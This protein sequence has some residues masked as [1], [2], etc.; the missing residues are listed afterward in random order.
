MKSEVEAAADGGQ[1]KCDEIHTTDPS[2]E[3][4]WVPSTSMKLTPAQRRAIELAANDPRHCV[5]ADPRTLRALLAKNLI[6]IS[7]WGEDMDGAVYRAFLG[8]PE[9]TI[10]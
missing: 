5:V 10:E 1:Q 2:A 3:P 8:P 7:Y 4:S 6:R 9:G